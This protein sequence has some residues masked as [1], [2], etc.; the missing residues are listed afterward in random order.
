VRPYVTFGY[1]VADNDGV[2]IQKT[3]I[4]PGLPRVDERV[5]L[6]GT[7]RAATFSGGLDFRVGD[8]TS[9]RAGVRLYA[10]HGKV[11][12]DPFT[13]ISPTVGAVFRW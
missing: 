12:I 4:A 8:R 1:G 2:W 13:I 9:I 7:F 11:D 6:D 5:A 10:I 3:V